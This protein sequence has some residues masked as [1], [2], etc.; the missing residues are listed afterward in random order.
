VAQR[1]DVTHGLVLFRQ[2]SAVIDSLRYGPALDSLSRELDGWMMLSPSSLREVTINAYGSPEGGRTLNLKL[3]RKRAENLRSWL[4]RHTSIPDNLFRIGTC[5]ISWAMLEAFVR[6]DN[7][8]PHR[9]EVL[10]VIGLP[11]ETRNAKGVLVDSRI[12]RLMN[13][14]YGRSY[15]YLDA[16]YFSRLRY[17]E[18][19]SDLLLEGLSRHDTIPF[20]EETP[21]AFQDNEDFKAAGTFKVET[22]PADTMGYRGGQDAFLAEDNRIVFVRRP[23]FAVKT[24]LLYDVALTPNIEVEVPL[25]NRWSLDGEF[26]HGWWD[27]KLF[28]YDF[29]WQLEALSAE[30]RYWLGDRTNRPVLTGWFVGAFAGAGV[31][32]LQL[33]RDKG[34]QGDFYI[35]AGL[36]AGYARQL[37]GNWRMEFSLGAGYLTTDYTRYRIV[38]RQLVRDGADM[39][40][41]GL[42]PLKVKISL[43]YLL[44]RG[45]KKKEAHK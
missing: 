36:S 42:L 20:K 9:D 19:V 15:H 24:N 45:A 38:D 30:G 3:A 8:V 12:H 13:V 26:L 29:C 40:F 31:Y 2:G 10:R 4:L 22:V 44:T 32:D 5:E 41:G 1:P 18:I 35:S 27:H 43:V 33:S 23:L 21:D 16:N 28:G 6:Q 34:Y 37:K 11:E 7:A 25:G 14:Y 17:G 39:R